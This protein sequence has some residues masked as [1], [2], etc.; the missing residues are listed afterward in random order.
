MCAMIDTYRLNFYSLAYFK[1]LEMLLFFNILKQALKTKFL[2]SFKIL[3]WLSVLKCTCSFLIN[4]F[5]GS[6]KY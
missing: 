6:L 3:T 5:T 4:C 2:K 1:I